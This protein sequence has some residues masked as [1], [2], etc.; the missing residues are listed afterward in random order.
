MNM[1][2]FRGG[3]VIGNDWQSFTLGAG[4]IAG[5]LSFDYAFIPNKSE[6]ELDAS[7]RI[8][9]TGKFGAAMPPVEVVEKPVEE[10]VAEEEPADLYY[11]PVETDDAWVRVQE[12]DERQP[13]IAVQ[14]IPAGLLVTMMIN[15]DFDKSDIRPDDYGI[16]QDVADILYTYPDAKVQL[17]G[18]TDNVGTDEYN[19][20][21]SLRRVES[22]QKYLIE[23]AGLHPERFL[24]AIGYGESRPLDTNTTPEGRFTNR[25]V[26]MVLFTNRD[27]LSSTGFSFDNYNPTGN[28]QMAAGMPEATPSTTQFAGEVGGLNYY[29][30]EGE[31]VIEITT[32]GQFTI[33]DFVLDNPP[34]IVCDFMGIDLKLNK[35]KYDVS[36]GNIKAIRI[37]HHQAEG[38]TRVVVDLVNS[39]NY[40]IE[41][42]YNLVRI[43]LPL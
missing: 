33:K 6:L 39:M 28:Y 11:F 36:N 17:L 15:F 38:F 9:I 4:F 34:R 14:Q 23:F 42:D 29:Q 20:K 2:A 5:D 3:Y 16:L 40:R 21:L 31:F 26:E 32:A 22:T 18:H 13:A 41:Q 43:I 35:K 7:H 1:L 30:R 24:Q 19:R 8:S 25:R 10:V 37:G 12:I 27:P